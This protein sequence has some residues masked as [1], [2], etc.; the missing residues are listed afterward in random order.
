MYDNYENFRRP[1]KLANGGV[2][3]GVGPV[4]LRWTI[5]WTPLTRRNLAAN[6][7][8]NLDDERII[9]GFEANWKFRSNKMIS[10]TGR[11][12]FNEPTRTLFGSPS[13]NILNRYFESGAFWTL[14][15]R[16]VF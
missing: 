13:V 16:G 6:G 8:S 4:D 3:V 1:T 10:L 15:F 14:G 11:N 5:N 2:N 9:Q 12:I 7:W